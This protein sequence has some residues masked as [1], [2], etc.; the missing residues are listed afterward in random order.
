MTFSDVRFLKRETITV[1]KNLWKS[2]CNPEKESEKNSETM[3]KIETEKIQ[4][5][6]KFL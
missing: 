5:M 4:K 2:S 6:L 3:E 1:K